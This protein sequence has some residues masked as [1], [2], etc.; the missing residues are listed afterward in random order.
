MPP[1]GYAV[2]ALVKAILG[3]HNNH[4]VIWPMDKNERAI[5]LDTRGPKLAKT[6]SPRWPKNNTTYVW[7]Y[8]SSYCIA[9]H[10]RR[11]PFKISRAFFLGCS[12]D[13]FLGCS[14]DYMCWFLD[15]GLAP[16]G[17]RSHPRPLDQNPSLVETS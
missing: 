10:P 6:S 5:S 3:I 11:T 2:Q 9:L 17:P 12:C 8:V 7:R 16:R 4:S 14:C 15:S 13:Y 1:K